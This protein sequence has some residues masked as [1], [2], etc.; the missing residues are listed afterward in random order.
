M[1]AVPGSEA[2]VHVGLGANLGDPE[3]TL[4]AAVEEIPCVFRAFRRVPQWSPA[5]CALPTQGKRV[6][7]SALLPVHAGWTGIGGKLPE[8]RG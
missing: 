7:F 2:L 6:V 4:A 1:T 3:R 8:R 5:G